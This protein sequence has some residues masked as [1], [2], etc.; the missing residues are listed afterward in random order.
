MFES[1]RN[2]WDLVKGSTRF[3]KK[4]PVFLIP[5]LAAWLVYAPV[6]VYVTWF[7]PWEGLSFP[8]VLLSVF[9]VIFVV[10]LLLTFSCSVLLEMV[11]QLEN[12]NRLSIVGALRESAG[13]DLSRIVGLALVWAVVW[14][15]LTVL[16]AFFSRKEKKVKQELT[17]ENVAEA[18]AGYGSLSWWRLSYDLLN[19]GIRMI[20]FLI[21]PAF[22]WEDRGLFASVRKGL[23]VLRAHLMEFA[24]GFT[25]TYLAA[26]IVFVPAGLMFYVAD[27]FDVVL[28]Q[29][30]WLV[31]I[32][33]MAFAWSYSM[34]LEQMFAADLYLWHL[35][36]EKACTEAERNGWQL[37]RLAD[38]SRPSL[39]D[40]V[41]ELRRG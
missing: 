38:I 5:L 16:E 30:V 29:L 7:F 15:G 1:A 21:M 37:P 23:G 27:E 24:S 17:A 9:L 25:L 31:T 39:L 32:I 13:R 33:Y 2:G 4:Y 14:F 40:E 22:A 20:V 26:A 8:F 19:K 34:Y 28:P 41:A 11:Q 36:W 12:G 35:K 18:L 10:T 6:V 3:F